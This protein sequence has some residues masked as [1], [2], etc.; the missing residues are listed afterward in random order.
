MVQNESGLHAGENQGGWVMGDFGSALA[1]MFW[2]YLMMAAMVVTFFAGIAW[3]VVWFFELHPL[4]W[5][6]GMVCS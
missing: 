3:L 4:L 1:Q 5:F 6:Q 2:P